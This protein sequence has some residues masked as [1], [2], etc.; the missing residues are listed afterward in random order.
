[1]LSLR[2]MADIF[3]RGLERLDGILDRLWFFVVRLLQFS[4]LAV[5]LIEISCL[6]RAAI[7]LALQLTVH[8][9]SAF[10]VQETLSLTAVGAFAGVKPNEIQVGQ[11]LLGSSLLRGDY[12]PFVFALGH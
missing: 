4:K 12:A 10:A 11:R 7:A 2:A 5:R 9:D 8:S 3:L 1:M 6:K